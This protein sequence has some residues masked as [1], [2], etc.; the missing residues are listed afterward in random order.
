MEP[1]TNYRS[2]PAG[3][4]A[5]GSGGRVAGQYVGEYDFGALVLIVV[6]DREFL[7]TYVPIAFVRG[8]F[9]PVLRGKLLP[10]ALVLGLAAD[11]QNARYIIFIFVSPLCL[12]PKVF[13]KLWKNG[14]TL[15]PEYS[16]HLHNR[17][18]WGEASRR[19]AA[20]AGEPA[21]RFHFICRLHFVSP[22]NLFRQL[23]EFGAEAVGLGFVVVHDGI[24]KQT[25]WPTVAL[26]R[27][28]LKSLDRLNLACPP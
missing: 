24:L 10:L 16:E 15:N 2:S 9:R 13:R 28:R 14:Q 4:D 20:L 26:A 3:V 7:P 12:S 27:R 1:P 21:M 11:I 17:L 18:W 25:A 8:K 22:L 23:A 19:A 5:V 6:F